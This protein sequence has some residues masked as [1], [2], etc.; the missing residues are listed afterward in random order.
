[1]DDGN[2]VNSASASREERAI[3]PDGLCNRQPSA[4]R[5][6]R[7]GRIMAFHDS[8]PRLTDCGENPPGHRKESRG[9]PQVA[10]LRGVCGAHPL[11]LPVLAGAIHGACNLGNTVDNIEDP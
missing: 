11:F 10:A 3:E 9:H 8:S 5:P 7:M 1:M 6:H 2:R 4:E